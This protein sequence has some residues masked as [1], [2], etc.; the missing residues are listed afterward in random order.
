MQAHFL[1]LQGVSKLLETVGLVREQINSR[2]RVAGVVLCMHD[3]QTSHSK[4]SRRRS[5]RVF[6][7]QRSTDTAWSSARVYHPAIRRNIKL[8]E[9][10]SF[11]QTIFQYA[12]W[13]P[14]AM[15][16]KKLGEDHRRRV[17][18]SA[19]GR[20]S[21]DL[22]DAEIR[23]LKG[24]KAMLEREP[25]E[26]S[27]ERTAEHAPEAAADIN[28]KPTNRLRPCSVSALFSMRWHYS[29]RRIGRG[30][31]SRADQP[32]GFGD[33]CRRVILVDGAVVLHTM[34]CDRSLRLLQ[35]PADLDGC[36]GA[37]VFSL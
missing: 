22:S 14:G 37:C 20:Q 18:S 29:R 32:D 1:A 6:E 5:R 31:R 21:S 27:V 11:G 30:L 34:D 16:Y 4:E 35:A 7:S 15:D 23:V 12:M 2:L 36:R 9:C 17:G 3:S 8:A 19:R 25:T 13:A 10:P 33:P 24:A 26:M 28:D